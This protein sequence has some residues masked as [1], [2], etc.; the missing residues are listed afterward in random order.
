MVT[1]TTGVSLQLSEYMNLNTRT[2]LPSI[3]SKY[4]GAEISSFV[5]ICALI[6][7]YSPC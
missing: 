4:V 3:V 1:V 2:I 5:C 6:L 7:E